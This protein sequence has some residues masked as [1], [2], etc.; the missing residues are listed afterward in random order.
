MAETAKKTILVTGGAGFIGS[1]LIERLVR[2]PANRVVSLDNY[3][4]GSREN[5]I[6]G[7]EYIEGHTKDIAKLINFVPDLVFHLGE[8]S[9]VAQSM[10]EP[11]V[12][13]D[14]NM[15]GTCAVLEFWRTHKFKFVYAGSSTKF[16][17][18]RVDGVEGKDLSPY[19]WIKSANTD[20]VKNYGTWY[21]LP[22]AIVYFYNVF[23][24][25]E[26]EGAYGT[27]IEIFKQKY[28]H[29][30]PLPVRSP[31]TQKRSYTHVDDTVDALILVAGKGEGDSYG[32]SSA[33]EYSIMEVAQMF[34]TEIEMLPA[35]STS[36]P[37][38]AVDTT[39]MSELGWEATRTLEDYIN[40][41]IKKNP[42][43]A[44]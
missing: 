29:N 43:T 42:R 35:R 44:Q 8:Y 37:S 33:K 28:L 36:R 24:P 5:H 34:K 20:L 4:T 7:A 19:T 2:D 22:Y 6:A 23:G 12:V 39:R 3:F 30:E 17:L 9:R 40:D 25:R 32:I 14:L 27:V 15:N 10:N 31:G 11:D 1:N 16:S 13:W 26:L 41:F 21:G 18:P 38:S